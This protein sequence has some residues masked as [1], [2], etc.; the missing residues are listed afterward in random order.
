MLKR[1]CSPR[2]ARGAFVL[3]GTIS[4]LGCQTPTDTQTVGRRELVIGVPEGLPVGDSGLNQVR[5]MLTTDGLT[6]MSVDGRIEPRLARQWKWETDRR[7]R[8]TLEEGVKLHSGESLTAT[9]AASIL[10]AAVELPRNR[11]QYP[12]FNSITG[13]TA[14]G[15]R[16]I[17]I[18]LSEPSAFLPEDLEVPLELGDPPRSTGAFRITNASN[19][20]LTLHS[21]EQYRG[22]TAGVDEVV[23]RAIPTLRTAWTNLLRGELDVVT[24]VPPDAVEFITND[25]VQVVS[26]ARRYQYAVTFNANRPALQSPV[27]R[28]ALNLAIDRESLITRALRGRGTP[29]TGPLWPQYWAYDSGVASYRFDTVEAETLLDSVGLHRGTLPG[30]NA[31]PPARLR[32]TCLVPTN[33]AIWERLALEVQRSLYAIGVDM[34]LQVV[35]FEQFD[36]LI[37]S[38][39]FDAAIID[40][41]SGP[42]PGRAY[43]FWRSARETTGLN[44]FGYENPEAE[45]LF[46]MLRVSTDETTVRSATRRL[47]RVFLDDPPALF[48]AWNERIRAIRRD[49]AIPEEA[50]RDPL[51]TLWRWMPNGAPRTTAAE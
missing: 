34:R 21:F 27:V 7:L 51:L 31:G 38:G 5:R 16:D 1:R 45:R 3:L 26:F 41:I 6:Q 22:G 47:Q 28:R 40:M 49:F 25:Q 46:D 30:T 8:V 13:I 43:I 19:S 42:T 35:P 29:A 33:F 50:G 24:D 9:T 39:K 2:V 4:L 44:V 15:Q 14:D 48:L 18:D 17:L 37:R 20:E 32:F 10:T 23:V 11:A 36:P 12:S